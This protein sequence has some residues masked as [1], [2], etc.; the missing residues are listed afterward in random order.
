M[1]SNFL[2]FL[3]FF[4]GISYKF[5]RV[6][7]YV[8]WISLKENFFRFCSSVQFEAYTTTFVC[9]PTHQRRC[10]RMCVCVCWCAYILYVCTQSV[11]GT[12]WF[13]WKTQSTIDISM[14]ICIHIHVSRDCGDSRRIRVWMC[15]WIVCEWVSVCVACWVSD[16][17]VCVCLWRRC[18]CNV[19][20]LCEHMKWVHLHRWTYT[21]QRI[22]RM[23]HEVDAT[24]NHVVIWYGG[25]AI[26]FFFFFF[27]AIS[28][29]FLPFDFAIRCQ[30][31]WIDTGCVTLSEIFLI[32]LEIIWQI[33]WMPYVIE[34]RSRKL[35]WKWKAN[36]L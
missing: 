5:V 2:S 3:A 17:C 21:S 25:S 7:L 6:L 13:G 32:L 4:T 15:S 16:E 19:T 8:G 26:F 20:H 10:V 31:L 29:A 1:Y 30:K 34:F 35:V 11:H 14:K 27:I 28:L 9:A 24:M 18:N 33:R 12:R 36:I 23:R 22:L